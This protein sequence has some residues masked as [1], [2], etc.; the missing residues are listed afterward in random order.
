MLG[1]RLLTYIQDD[2]SHLFI[3]LTPNEHHDY[4]R[5]APFVRP[6]L[7]WSSSGLVIITLTSW[8]VIG[9]K[10][11]SG[12]WQAAKPPRGRFYGKP[13]SQ[14]Q[15]P[16]TRILDIAFCLAFFR[17]EEFTSRSNMFHL[18]TV[19]NI[20]DTQLHLHER[21]FTLQL[22]RSKS[23]SEH[24]P[25]PDYDGPAADKEWHVNSHVTHC[26]PL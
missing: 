26:L 7:V 16:R 12:S 5:R 8:V 1:L 22:K 18:L 3:A 17:F 23:D 9:F 6:P 19:L 11:V 21:Y 2:G 4:P 15:E 20:D 14:G 10:R 24:L 13:L 25:F